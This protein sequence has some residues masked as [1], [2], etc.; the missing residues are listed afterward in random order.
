MLPVLRLVAPSLPYFAQGGVMEPL[1]VTIMLW[2]SANLG[3]PANIDPPKVTFVSPT[4]LIS[5]R[6]APRWRR[7]R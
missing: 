1:L 5:L 6:Y 7:I 4:E 3:L 2:V